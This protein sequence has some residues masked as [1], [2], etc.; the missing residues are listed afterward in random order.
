VEPR[1][2]LWRNVKF[3][4]QIR[5]INVDINTSLGTWR[6]DLS[7]TSNEILKWTTLSLLSYVATA[8]VVDVPWGEVA[9]HTFV[10]SFIWQKDY[11]VTIVA[12]LGTTITPYCF[13]WQ[14]SQE[15]EDE[16]IDSAA[17]PLLE[18]P[19]E[20]SAEIGRIRLDT[21]LGMGLS[22]L[23]SLFI[24]VTTAA[25][26]PMRLERHWGGRPD[27]IGNLSRRR[28]STAPSRWRRSSAS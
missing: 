24:I 16:R 2:A 23:I 18:A 3:F 17:H 10:P 28:R 13:F 14:S 20:A 5:G 25:T 4:D 9:Y 21:Y 8:L 19:E 1:I 12:V 27:S 6:E 22:N 11:I 26:L 15:A 7:F